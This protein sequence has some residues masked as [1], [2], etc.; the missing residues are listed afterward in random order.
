MKVHSSPGVAVR[1]TGVEPSAPGDRRRVEF[2]IRVA[3]ASALAFQVFQRF[4]NNGY[5]LSAY[6][7][8]L[9]Y[10]SYEFGFVRRG[11]AG[12]LL[13]RALG[14]TPTVP[15]VAMVQNAIA[16]ITVM[17]AAWLV[18]VLCRQRT[19]I[20]YAIAALLAVSPFGF[21]FVGGSKRPDLV[22]FLLLALVA[23]WSTTTRV[24]PIVLGAVSGALLA[25]S[26]LFSEAGPLV[27]APWLVLLVLVLARSRG[28]SRWECGIAGVLA[29][30]PSV[31][32]LGA[33]AL[34]GRASAAA[35]AA[36][37]Q[38]APLDVGGRGTVFP[39]L[40]DTV[41]VSMGKVGTR[42]PVTSLVV[43]AF[44]VGTICF[45]GRRLRPVVASVISWAL[46]TPAWRRLWSVGFVGVTVLL[47]GL[48]FDW[49]RWVTSIMFAASLAGGAI[50]VIVGRGVTAPEDM[51][52][53]Y[54]PVPSRV[55]LSLPAVT[56]LAIAGYL[57]LLPPLP[58]AVDNIGRAAH[59]LMNAPG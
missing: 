15:Q 40:D 36:L 38:V 29:A 16:V 30:A 20:G 2:A 51:I 59:L 31:L 26:A 32:A 27:V 4:V 47:F 25:L 48:G 1:R 53:W 7:R 11:L 44:L 19:V 22:A 50:V 45:L 23:V 55:L 28:R 42:F 49:M 24:D 21:D 10:V 9:W 3:I 5:E 13:R 35:V 17:A 54:R 6:G 46:P 34:T 43:G 39:Y 12:E 37:E 52:R 8:S 33:L 14:H 57:L 18:V 41:L 58:T 56:S